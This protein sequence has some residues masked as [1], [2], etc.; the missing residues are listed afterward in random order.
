MKLTILFSLIC[1]SLFAQPRVSTLVPV[2][3]TTGTSAGLIPFR[4]SGVDYRIPVDTSKIKASTFQ[5]RFI[6]YNPEAYSVHKEL[7]YNYFLNLKTTESYLVCE[8]LLDIYEK[9]TGKELNGEVL[10]NYLQERNFLVAW[11]GMVEDVEDT[12]TKVFKL[13]KEQLSEILNLK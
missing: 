5:D 4:G 11:Y 10:Y 2:S 7:E 1:F 3:T 12:K 13:S 9:F 6:S 8:S